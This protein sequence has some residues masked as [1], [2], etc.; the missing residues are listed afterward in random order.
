M[1]DKP[2]TVTIF[3][4]VGKPQILKESTA[5]KL[6]CT[7]YDGMLLVVA[8]DKLTDKVLKSYNGLPFITD[9]F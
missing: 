1:A 3:M 6:E 8:R 2:K 9:G 7:N 5:V 4:P